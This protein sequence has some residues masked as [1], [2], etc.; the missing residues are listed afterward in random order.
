MKNHE[1]GGLPKLKKEKIIDGNFIALLESRD[2][3]V[4]TPMS[5]FFGGNRRSDSYGSSVEFADYRE[6]TRGDD[7][8]RIDWNLYARFEKLFLKLFVD[9]RQ[10]HHRIYIDASA[11]MDWGKPSKAHAALKLAAA[12]G[13][14]AVQA[15]DRVSFYALSGDK[16]RVISRNVFGREA[17]YAAADALNDVAFGG[18]S[19]IGEAINSS[20]DI[21]RGDGLSVIISDFL[22]DNPWKSGVDRLVYNKRQVELVQVL[23]RDE[24][25]PNLHG[26]VFMLDAEAVE[27]EDER[28]YRHEI[29]RSAMKAY[30]E[31]FLYHQNMI[32]DFARSREAG[33]ITFCSDESIERVLFKNAVEGGLMK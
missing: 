24:V 27:E 3:C 28:N 5:G 4:R 19:M 26:K 21:G 23:S 17:F 15:M 11:S 20:E 18:E 8:R 6:Y 13:F 2:L 29:T 14:L 31:A 9:E 30:D 7:I 10:L 16:C 1:F 32:R 33:F 12:L 25:S 22:T